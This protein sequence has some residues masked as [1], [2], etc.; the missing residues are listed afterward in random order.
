[1]DRKGSNSALKELKETAAEIEERFQTHADAS[2]RFS[3]LILRSQTKNSTI[4]SSNM[5][6][7]KK[8]TWTLTTRAVHWKQLL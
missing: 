8:V 5:E 4:Y 1:M 7:W 2:L 3:I 6:Q